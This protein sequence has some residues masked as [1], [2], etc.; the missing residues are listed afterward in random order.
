MLAKQDASER[1]LTQYLLLRDDWEQG[2]GPASA[3]GIE[4]IDEKETDVRALA[5]EALARHNARMGLPN[6]ASSTLTDERY[7]APVGIGAVLGDM[8][9]RRRM[10]SSRFGESSVLRDCF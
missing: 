6:S 7:K 9:R 2:T 4:E 5:W 8:D 3:A 10:T 1:A